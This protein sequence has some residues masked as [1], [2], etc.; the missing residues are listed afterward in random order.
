M[1]VEIPTLLV[2]SAANPLSGTPT[3]TGP[4]TVTIPLEQLNAFTAMQARLAEV[5]EEQQRRDETTRASRCRFSRQKAKLR[6]LFA[7]SVNRP[8]ETYRP[9]VP[10]VFKSKNVPN[11]MLLMANWYELWHHN[12]SF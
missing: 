9:N 5:E 2:T 12:R 3:I 7:L 10:P 6:R 4:Q 1:S 8:N 11:V